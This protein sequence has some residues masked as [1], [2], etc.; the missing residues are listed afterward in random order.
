VACKNEADKHK[1]HTEIKESYT[2]PMHPQIIK[3]A[4]GNCPICGMKLVPKEDGKEKQAIKDT[5][6]SALLKPTNEFAI[7]SIPTVKTIHKYLPLTL[8]ALG[9]VSYDTRQ[10]G[11]VSANISGRI[12]KLYVRSRYQQV[13]KGQRI[14]DIYSPEILTAQENLLMVL[15]NDPSNEMMISSAKQKLLLLGMSGQ[16]LQE[17]IKKGKPDFSIS[18]FSNYNGYIKDVQEECREK[19]LRL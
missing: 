13:K 9:A 15:R 14:M 16:Q 8:K 12:E 3:D 18:V 7:S 10:M 6:L 17:V 19:L 1:G 11:S 2:C 5:A 4:P